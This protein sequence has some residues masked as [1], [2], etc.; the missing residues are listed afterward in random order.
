MDKREFLKTSGALLASTLSS[1][2]TAAQ[3]SADSRTNWAGNYTYSTKNLDLQTPSK[4]PNTASAA[5]LILRRS[6]RGIPSTTLP[7]ARKTR[8]R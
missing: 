1:K 2:L 6:V 4:M 5:T 8:Y 7:I 3:T